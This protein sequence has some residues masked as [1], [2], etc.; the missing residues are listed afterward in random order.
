MRYRV[1]ILFPAEAP[2]R[3]SIKIE[4]TRLADI[5]A[6]L[7]GVGIE[8]EGAPYSDE[9]VDHVRTQLLLFDGVLV[10]V[11]PIEQDHDR[12]IL[13]ALLEDVAAAGVFVSAHPEVIRK[14]G[15]K[16]VLYRTRSM[17]WGCDTRL[18]PTL[19]ALRDELP[20]SLAGG[21]PRVLKQVRGNG[22]NGVWKIEPTTPSAM[23][24][25][26]LDPGARVRVRHAKRGSDEEEISLGAF[27]QRCE[28]Y[29]SGNGRLV[30]Q[31]YQ[32]RL[33]DGMVRCY[34]VG[35]RVAGFGEQLVNAL[36]P[37]R[38]GATP[39][40]PGPRLYYPPTRPDFQPLKHLMENE[41][42]AELCQTLA[43]DAAL[44]PM[45]WDADFLYGQ[46]DSS[47]ADTYTLCEINVSSVY[48]FPE[49]ALAPLAA[50]TLAKLE[51]KR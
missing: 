26:A 6:A 36:Y 10:W 15:T 43:L 30:D 3:Q 28:P 29:F 13:D 9:A 2:L 39:P 50:A 21:E 35:D 11:N 31:A 20:R 48:P 14:I 45:I 12:S 51:T 44:L 25:S 38:N 1:A 18:Y 17:S 7:R 22:G 24:A 5:A 33:T 23:G 49:E 19:Q 46:K 27:L 42:L 8:V 47:G 4:E 37:A 34:L 40:T 32:P 16:E 41:W